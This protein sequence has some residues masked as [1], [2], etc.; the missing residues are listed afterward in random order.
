M[1]I[2]VGRVGN[3]VPSGYSEAG[4]YSED[5]LFGEV[6]SLDLSME[7]LPDNEMHPV[8]RRMIDNA[9]EG[10]RRRNGNTPSGAWVEGMPEDECIVSVMDTRNPEGNVRYAVVFMDRKQPY[11]KPPEEVDIAA[12]VIKPDSTS[13]RARR[14]YADGV[15]RLRLLGGAGEVAKTVMERLPLTE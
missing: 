6:E 7:N 13:I 4:L 3:N 1:S 10:Y 11:T 12:V 8:M 14:I 2:A 5:T 9:S 15:Q